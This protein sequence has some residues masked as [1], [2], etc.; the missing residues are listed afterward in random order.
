MAV[1]YL[2]Q[3]THQYIIIFLNEW[4]NIICNLLLKMLHFVA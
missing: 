3:E 2:N 1:V 4:N